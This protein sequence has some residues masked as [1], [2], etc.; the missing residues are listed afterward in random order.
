VYNLFALTDE[1]IERG[2]R[3]LLLPCPIGR[4]RT[5]QGAFLIQ[6]SSYPNTGLCYI[7]SKMKM[8]AA[9]SG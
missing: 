9:I 8:E 5:L 1:E 2:K 4:V 7:R 3:K 6:T